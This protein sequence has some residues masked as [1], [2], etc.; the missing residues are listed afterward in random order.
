[1]S[2]VNVTASATPAAAGGTRRCPAA[3]RST[4]ARPVAT[5][6]PTASSRWQERRAPPRTGGLNGQSSIEELPR[7][8]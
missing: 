3:A 5:M 6:K 1:M 4:L 2:L 8:Q 7:S